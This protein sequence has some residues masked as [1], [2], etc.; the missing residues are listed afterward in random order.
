M[1]HS[2]E[3]ERDNT[4]Y[5]MTGALPED[6]KL[7]QNIVV[8]NQHYEVIDGILHHKN[9]NSPGNWCVVVPSQLQTQLL[10]EAHSGCFGGHFSEKRCMRSSGV[11]IGGM[12]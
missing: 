5:H 1:K 8:E 2:N 9:P 4:E 11:I 10:T 7:A 12:V 3:P 6:Q